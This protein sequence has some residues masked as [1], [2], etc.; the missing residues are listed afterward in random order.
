[1][2]T[3]FHHC[4]ARTANSH[5][6]HS[7]QHG[8][9]VPVS[10][11]GLKQPAVSACAAEVGLHM[12]PHQPGASCSGQVE[13]VCCGDWIYECELSQQCCSVKEVFHCKQ[14]V[15]AVN[16]IDESTETEPKHWSCSCKTH[17]DNELKEAKMLH[18]AERSCSV[19]GSSLWAKFH[20]NM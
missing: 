19:V 6:S 13:V 15:D 11:I 17:N 18:R 1:M 8:R 4:G 14:P 9:Q 10:W 7:Q 5:L 12:Q 3:L 2:G 20:F 16:N